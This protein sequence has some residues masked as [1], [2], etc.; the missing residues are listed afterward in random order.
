MRF[1]IQQMQKSF[2]LLLILLV[3]NLTACDAAAT[4]PT[5]TPL[6]PAPITATVTETAA[7]T[8][9]LFPTS[10]PTITPVP[11][12][13]LS[14]F[15]D[16]ELKA[17]VDQLAADFLKDTRDPGLSIA[18]VKRDPLTGQLR[19]M[20]L[21]YG[22]MSK[23]TRQPVASDTVYEIGSITKVFTGVL[24][25]KAIHD[26]KANLDDPLQNYLPPGI[27]APSYDNIPITLANL[28]THRSS[29]PRDFGSDDMQELY[30]WLNT[31]RL[32][33]APG[34]EYVYSNVGYE[35]LGDI[36]A[37]LYGND[38]GALEFQSVS[39]PLGMLDTTET[40]SSDQED[41]LAQGYDYYGS[42]APY[43]PQSGAMGP[44][45]YL[46]S[47]LHDMAVFL[48]ANMQPDSTPLAS[49]LKLAQVSQAQGRNPGTGAGLGWNMDHPNTPYERI[50]KDGATNGFSS[51]VS[52]VRDGSSGFVLLANGQ[53]IDNL[54]SD[55]IQLLGE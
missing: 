12:I 24:L 32:D 33:H 18:I 31:L 25:A 53:Y 43:F 19:T 1:I 46:H 16:D 21:N 8:D 13:Q 10:T 20:L 48:A 26:G 44:A 51:Y 40:L 9:V 28:A 45:G 39:K 27:Q 52:F 15:N 34:S 4:A 55:M 30:T 37:R 42:G 22:V 38:F 5:Q 2:V 29:L 3:L 36:L 7:P 11:T 47:T 35:L 50:W 54:A 6:P 14:L 49:A 17:Q 41:R 23:D